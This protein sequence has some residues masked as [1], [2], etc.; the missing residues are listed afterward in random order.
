MTPSTDNINFYFPPRA[1]S[2]HTYGDG[3]YTITSSGLILSRVVVCFSYDIM[4]QSK[5]SSPV[6]C[7]TTIWP[8]NFIIKFHLSSELEKKYGKSTR[9]Y[10]YSLIQFAYA[11]HHL[12]PTIS[13]TD[14]FPVL[15]V[16]AV[17]DGGLPP[18]G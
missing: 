6:A 7:Q 11:C 2:K 18:L 8:F 15:F 9:A 14:P 5:A 4:S 10:M 3:Y 12:P 16:F 13:T 1:P 17:E